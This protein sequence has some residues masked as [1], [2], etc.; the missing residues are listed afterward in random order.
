MQIADVTP[1]AGDAVK[2]AGSDAAN[3]AAKGILDAL[4]GKKKKPPVR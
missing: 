3:K 4:S 2:A 1:S